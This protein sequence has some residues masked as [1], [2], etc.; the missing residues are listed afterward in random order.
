M[1]TRP[2]SSTTCLPTSGGRPDSIGKSE[3]DS[4]FHP[5][6]SP[7]PSRERITR[8]R[9]R[10]LLGVAFFCIRPLDKETQGVMDLV[11]ERGCE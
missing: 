6:L 8:G 11:P 3:G 7:L 9:V 2:A 5:H 10:G 4:L 1:S